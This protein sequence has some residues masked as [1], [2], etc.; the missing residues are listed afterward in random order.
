MQR[1]SLLFI[2]LFT[3]AY[4]SAC[5]SGEATETIKPVKDKTDI[6]IRVATDVHYLAPELTDFGEAFK[7]YV[8]SGDGKALQVSDE[9][10]D[11]FLAD[12]SKDQA[13]ILILSGDLTNNGERKSHENL[14]KKLEKVEKS[15]T[16]VY[17]I[18]GNHDINNPWARSFKADKQYKTDSITPEEFAKIYENFGLKEAVLKDKFSLSYLAPASKDIWLLMLDTNHYKSNMQLGSP[19]TDGGLTTGTL[20]WIKECADL[21]KANN[22]K[23]VPV[24]H[25]NLMN[26][27][28]IL[29][30]GY[31]INYAEDVQNAFKKANFT[32]ALSGHIHTQNIATDGKLTDI[33]TNALSVYPHK[34]GK[35]TY[36][37]E[38]AL[39]NYQTGKVNLEEYAKQNNLTSDKFLSF[40]QKDYDQFYL[41]GYGKAMEDLA[42]SDDFDSYSEQEKEAM[43]DTMA[44][45]NLSYFAGVAP[46]KSD[47][48]K[49]WQ[50]APNSFLKKYVISTS[51]APKRS[52]DEWTGK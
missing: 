2:L 36:S 51:G 25:H 21:A 10:T 49:L 44:L 24:M 13:D 22:V 27:S 18:P 38:K 7:T 39:F 43:A 48:L 41:N 34:Y 29:Q 37:G 26:H 17:V 40:N 11:A 28:E 30:Q 42:T 1:F 50:S 47:G 33:T 5:S 23:I 31:T 3:C 35:I 16:D 19:Q 4:L 14:A 32:F 46:P 20:E 6:S 15:G 8:A 9:M 12:V 45:N 52:N